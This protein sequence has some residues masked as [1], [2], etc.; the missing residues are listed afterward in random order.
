MKKEI[1]V[2]VVGALV[3]MLLSLSVAHAGLS[4][5]QPSLVAVAPEHVFTPPGFD[6]NDNSQIVVAGNLMN[7]C[8]KVGPATTQINPKA[9]KIVIRTQAYHYESSWCI[10]MLIPYIQ[11]IDLGM[12]PLG[13]YDVFV[14]DTSGKQK[15]M[16]TLPIS[17]SANT[18]PDDAL[19]A[20]VT[21]AYIEK[22][23]ESKSPVM[24]LSGVMTSSCM[25]LKQVNVKYRA[26]NVV[27][28]FPLATIRA[29]QDCKT[30]SRP[31]SAKVTVQ[32]PWK[33][34]TLIHVRALNGQAINKV[35]DF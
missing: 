35:F 24:T 18:G 1:G 3:S 15:S 33:G 29:H 26:P 32:A 17:E 6:D 8:F 14:E 5:S 13:I 4:G 28:I 22:T 34:T 12:L 19:Y 2:F 7:T 9:R 10:Y 27:E 25:E 31:F 21:E 30:I 23:E 20:P 11:T 16:G